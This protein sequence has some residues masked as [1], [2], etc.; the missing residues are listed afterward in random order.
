MKYF[1]ERVSITLP[2]S[3]K[4][5]F[6]ILHLPVGVKSAPCALFCN[7][8]GGHKCGKFRL[9]VRQAER[10][11]QNGIA[12]FRFDYR[13]TGD[14][15]GGFDEITIQS[16]L[17]DISVCVEFLTKH[18]AI[19]SNRLAI[20]GRSLGGAL[21]TMSAN[22]HKP[23]TVVLWAPLFDTLPW[24]SK[25]VMHK[26]L[27]ITDDNKVY[28]A[29]TLLSPSL[30]SELQKIEIYPDL[31]AISTMPLLILH[32]EKDSVLGMY[33]F[34]KYVEARKVASAVTSTITLPG[35]DHEFDIPEEQ[36]IVLQKTAD[37]L[38]SHL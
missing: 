30:L 38:S 6:G 33:H 23:K 24:F 10:L 13:G 37:W 32:G 15:E 25:D 36:E 5:I 1:E 8:F 31:T 21:A 20:L 34:N 18:G 22:H 11:V 28:F 26:A 2:S 29:G 3:G 17:D 16:Q 35:S 19:D 12:S 4:K 7:G 27:R 14:S 9:S